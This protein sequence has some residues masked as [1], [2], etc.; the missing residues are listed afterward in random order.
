MNPAVR[1]AGTFTALILFATAAQAQVWA[2]DL[3]VGRALYDPVAATVGTSNLVAALRYGGG[4]SSMLYA[5]AAA[6]LGSDAPW[7]GAVGGTGRLPLLRTDGPATAGRS[8]G[9]DLG[10]H[11]YLFRD[12]VSSSTGHGAT[13]DAGAYARLDAGT[14]ALEGRA[15]WLQHESSLG[16]DR[17]SRGALDVGARLEYVARP[18]LGLGAGGRWM[19]TEEGGFPAVS[20]DV[21]GAVGVFR[22]W[23]TAE[24]WLASDMQDTGW[25]AGLT[26]QL[27]FA[28][29]W[30]S[31]RRDTRDPLYWNPQ[32]RNW[33]VGIT[34]RLGPRPAPRL[35][36]V[37]RE[38]AAVL[39][40][41]A[42]SDRAAVSVAG[43]FS[44]WQP[45]PM[46]RSDGTW[47][48]ELALDA[49][50]YRYSFVDADGQWFVP[51]SVPGRMSDGMGG[52]VA[53][54]VVP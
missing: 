28:D 49:G 35:M 17:T 34:R 16:D 37:I 27:A 11:G 39:R 20:A 4:R 7:W 6:P 2:A 41:P 52:H 32:R 30:V 1:T 23:V 26:V 5:S 21:T 36:P 47:E 22:A 54:L 43:D 13:L 25:G 50:V 44:D 53:V 24:Q 42:S 18:G 3:Y 19:Q 15:S 29:A 8:A 40:L 14:G 38:G 48:L 31:F 45:I 33:S 12:P 51:E 10:G 9:L 46:R